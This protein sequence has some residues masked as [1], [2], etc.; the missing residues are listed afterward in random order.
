MKFSDSNTEVTMLGLMGLGLIGSFG[1]AIAMGIVLKNFW[2]VLLIFIGLSNLLGA[3]GQVKGSKRKTSVADLIFLMVIG[4]GAIIGAFFVVKFQGGWLW[5]TILITV[6]DML[7]WMGFSLMELRYGASVLV[8]VILGFAALAFAVMGPI[9]FLDDL[10][11][12]V[13]GS[14]GAPPDV[15]DVAEVTEEVTETEAPTPTQTEAPT[16]AP[17]EE[18]PE[19]TEVETEVMITPSTEPGDTLDGVGK[20]GIKQFFSALF[21]NYW[22]MAYLFIFALIGQFALRKWGGLLFLVGSILIIFI[23][24]FISPQLFNKLFFIFRSS[25]I[26]FWQVIVLSGAMTF[27]SAGWALL[28]IG[29]FLTVIGAP[30]QINI[31]VFSQFFSDK[32]SRRQYRRNTPKILDIVGNLLFLV[33]VGSAIAFLWIYLSGDI[34]PPSLAFLSI[35][36]VTL[37]GW[38]YVSNVIIYV[39]ASILFGLFFWISKVQYHLESGLFAFLGDDVNPFFILL[40]CLVIAALVPVGVLLFIIG[41]A[42]GMVVVYTSL[43]QIG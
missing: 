20:P 11:K 34:L 14:G 3:V 28:M 41:A 43:N 22:G 17:T 30:L 19:P 27:K 32:A 18:T 39:L 42:A 26:D 10:N 40:P 24:G 29:F 36:N 15:T 38:E 13:Y 9:S 6:A 7:L 8:V 4:L 35:E 31:F 23:I 16:E 1:T 37:S 33:V 25:P 2:V 12:S 5:T 21:K